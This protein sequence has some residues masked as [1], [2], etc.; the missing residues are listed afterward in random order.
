MKEVRQFLGRIWQLILL[1][2]IF[3]G[4][5]FYA[6]FQGNTVSWAIFYAQLPFTLYALLVHLYPLSLITVERR[7][8][9][10]R[11]QYG[12]DLQVTITARKK[13]PFPHFYVILYDRWFL[14]GAETPIYEAKKMRIFSFRKEITWQYTIEQMP[15]GEYEAPQVH[16]DVADILNWVERAKAVDLYTNVIV[17]P[18]T[19]M[20]TE[21]WA[22]FANETGRHMNPLQAIQDVLSVASIRAYEHGDRLSW[23]HWKSFAKTNELMTKEFDQQEAAQGLLL[24]DPRTT[25][26]LEARITFTASMVARAEREKMAIRFCHL[27]N[28]AQLYST[29]SFKDVEQIFTLLA[30][31]TETAQDRLAMEAIIHARRRNEAIIIV[32]ASI[33]WSIIETLM[34]TAARNQLLLF[35]VLEDQGMFEP[36][37]ADIARAKQ[38]GVRVYPVIGERMVRTEKEVK[39]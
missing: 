13:I 15:R 31:T 27:E 21:E 35:L 23:V 3:S 2:V 11:L 18:Q 32:T 24:F 20:L 1:L 8:E 10:R 26:S 22:M 7:V 34:R 5:L 16:I 12:E 37:Q 29:G 28:P 39:G 6:L 17:F 14:K 4:A 9:G 33:D 30:K 25:D 19:V 38:K 36:M